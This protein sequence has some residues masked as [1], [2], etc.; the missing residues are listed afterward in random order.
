MTIIEQMQRLFPRGPVFPET[1]IFGDATVSC[2]AR[3]YGDATVFN[4]TEPF[5]YDWLFDDTQCED[6]KCWRKEWMI[7]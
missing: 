7:T 2:G 6:H 5:G 3:V 4:N 1:Q